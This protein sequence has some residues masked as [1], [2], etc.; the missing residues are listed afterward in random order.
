MKR[1]VL[2]ILILLSTIFVN[3]IALAV[4]VIT[5]RVC[6]IDRENRLLTIKP[7]ERGADIITIKFNKGRIPHGLKKGEFVKVRGNFL[8]G[9]NGTIL[10]SR[11]IWC[12]RQN[13][14]ALDKTGV[15]RRLF[16]GRG[17][18]LGSRHKGHKGHGRHGR[19]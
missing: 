17:W 2:F 11:K 4:D 7:L 14:H 6:S 5:G 18:G 12:S 13:S 1:M 15:R 16:Q 8:T 3:D 9:E 19:H 10:K